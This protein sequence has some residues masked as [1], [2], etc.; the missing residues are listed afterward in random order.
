MPLYLQGDKSLAE[1]CAYCGSQI[2]LARSVKGELS[3]SSEQTELHLQAQSLRTFAR[4][5]SLSSQPPSYELTATKPLASQFQRALQNTGLN[6]TVD[7]ADQPPAEAPS[8]SPTAVSPPSLKYLNGIRSALSQLPLPDPA[9]LDDF[10][11]RHLAFPIEPKPLPS[12]AEANRLEAESESV[13]RP[14]QQPWDHFLQNTHVAAPVQSEP[15]SS[16]VAEVPGTVSHPVPEKVAAPMPDKTEP[17]ATEPRSSI[18]LWTIRAIAAGIAMLVLGALLFGPS[19]NKSQPSVAAKDSS[20]GEMLPVPDSSV[21][22]PTLTPI[23][24]ATQVQPQAVSAKVLPLVSTGGKSHASI[25]ATGPSWVVACADGKVLFAKLFTSGGK[26]NVDFTSTAIVRT[27]SAGSLQIEVDGE[28]VGTLG[29]VGQ[30]RIVE[31]TPGASHFRT[32]GETD[33]CTKGR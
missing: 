27:G 21:R 33:D 4:I 31:L 18:R 3:C 2:G 25:Q 16:N 30:V 14:T 11:Q 26:D 6:G 10:E 32:G 13:L 12:T 20:R 29:A 15:I 23:A 17:S 24:A 8:N 9:P 7:V 1:I 22:K 5:L 19:S 28:P